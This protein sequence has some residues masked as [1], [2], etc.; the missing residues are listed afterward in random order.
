MN[1]KAYI[2][3]LALA[4]VCLTF[5]LLTGCSSSSNNT[6]STVTPASAAATQSATVGT[7]FTTALS[8]T[9]TNSSGAPLNNIS[10]TFT[11]P[12][13]GASGTFASN[14]TATETD[15]TNSSGVATASAFTAN[16]TAGAYTVTAAAGT[17]SG[18]FS[19]TNTAG[20]PATVTATGGNNQSIAI[21]TTYA[22]LSATVVDADNNP[23]SGVS[24]TF[25]AVA[26]SSGASA[27]FS[28]AGP[29][30]E[31]TNASGVATTSQTLTANGI[32]GGFT[33][34]ATASGVT[35]PATF[36][37]TNTATVVTS[38][39]YVFYASGQELPNANNGGLQ[40]YYAIAGAV[41][42]DAS[43]DILA[44]EQDYND[45]SGI[46][47][48]DTITAE[49]TALVVDPTTGVGTLTITTAD[50]LVGVGGVETFAI[51]FV[52]SNHAYLTQFDG[53]ATSSGS[54]DLQNLTL[55]TAGASS[56]AIS[57]VDPSYDSVAFG[58]VIAAPS[59]GS[60]AV[61]LDAN[62]D[63]TPSTGNSYTATLGTPDSF[64]RTL[65]T[66]IS[67]PVAASA[68][69]FAA[70][71]VT[72]EAIRI[73]DID[74]T[75]SAVGSAY[76]QGTAAG[77]FSV[78]SLG[79]TTPYVFT[80]LGQW[81]EQYGTLGQFSTDGNGNITSGTA[82]DNELDNGVLEVA[83]TLTGTYLIGTNG[84][85]SLSPVWGSGLENVVQQ[86]LYMVDP[87]LDINDP[88]NTTSAD[89]G[90]AV[91]VDL[92]LTGVTAGGIGVITP[93]TDLTQA[94]FSGNY[95]AGF[96]DYNNF[97][98]TTASCI[99][100]C[101]FDMVGPF[102]M[103]ATTGPFATATIGAEDSDPFGTWD[104]TPGES[105]GDTFTLT[106]TFVSAGY[107]SGGTI[108]ATINTVPGGMTADLYQASGTTLYWIEIDPS[109]V[110]I[111][112]IEAQGSL[113]TMPATKK[114]GR[115]QSRGAKP[116]NLHG[117]P[118]H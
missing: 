110:F 71:P 38:N 77:T 20:A 41:T 45:A 82:D 80:L 66:G 99:V 13:S 85:G 97:G 49:P 88:N 16:T 101:E 98:F 105:T 22:P 75:D 29:D 32:V 39:T 107:Y 5:G 64:G 69:T 83:D 92:S 60:A 94:D 70:Y 95:A 62:D 42:V 28:S 35:T 12:A 31:T 108:S 57:G 65:I 113:S 37:E 61:T 102:S 44:G 89:V 87:A 18:S 9:V 90:G 54:F 112:P 68:I 21:N 59:S 6:P 40:S 23:V 8:V 48:T 14:S 111:G 58:G 2:S 34:T 67:N 4:L 79:T 50:A 19:L 116:T 100:F 33:V 7:A 56:F 51:Q 118:A 117:G 43:G 63:G 81:S 109:G 53:T 24:V 114:S 84:Y 3:I 86:G 104:G 52:N 1:R 115:A 15:T 27:A 55:G 30:T 72:L 73:I 36:T 47:E 103:T 10:V 76:G 26:G 78:A 17:A 25:A 93:A 106:P 46:T 91:L 96:Q 74:T 11:A